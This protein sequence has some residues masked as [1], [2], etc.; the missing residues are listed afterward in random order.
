MRD[1]KYNPSTILSGRDPAYMYCRVRKASIWTLRKWA[2]QG[3]LH[4][5]TSHCMLP[6]YQQGFLTRE[7]RKCLAK[8]DLYLKLP[9]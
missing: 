3:L 5:G 7:L 1:K 8:G 2:R 4:D 9:K 6:V